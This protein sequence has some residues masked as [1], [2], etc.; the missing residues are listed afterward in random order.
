M[1]LIESQPD[2][3]AQTY[4]KSLLDLCMAQGGQA[5]AQ[6]ALDQ[7]R[8]V[9]ALARE[10]RSFGE[11]LSSRI[12]GVK[13]RR[14][15]LA[16]ILTGRCEQRVLNFLLVLNDKGRLSRL[17]AIVAAFDQEAQNSFGN[18]EIDVTTPAPLSDDAA[19]SLADNLRNR[20]GRE[21]VLHRSVDPTMIGG[22][23]LKIGDQL[24]D[25]SLSTRLRRLRER[26]AEN[27]APQVRAAA[28][29]IFAV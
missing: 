8:D 18:I 14:K 15:S 20:L 1:P 29:R 5:A 9:L 10:D 24:L 23:R 4:A 17:P 19:R 22:V 3:V 27:G 11:F 26:M 12:I 16:A 2:A 6:S 28:E 7:L 25:A 21:P 13:E